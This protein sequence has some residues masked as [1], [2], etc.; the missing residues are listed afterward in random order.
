[1]DL[2]VL[3]VTNLLKAFAKKYVVMGKTWDH[4]QV[5]VMTETLKTVMVAHLTVKLSLVMIAV[6]VVITQ[7][8]C[9][10]RYAEMG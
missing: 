5:L 6:K 4:R 8:T 2:P 7:E 3:K 10:V 1:M 9:V